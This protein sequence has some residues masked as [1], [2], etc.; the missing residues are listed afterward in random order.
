MRAPTLCGEN[1]E[2]RKASLSVL[3]WAHMDPV[4]HQR[5]PPRVLAWW[6]FVMAIFMGPLGM[7][8]PGLYQEGSSCTTDC[9]CESDG[10][11]LGS[12]SDAFHS[13][14]NKA[15]AKDRC[16][17]ECTGCS[18]AHSLVALPSRASHISLASPPAS[19][20]AVALKAPPSSGTS[21]GVFR[22][23]RA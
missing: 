2:E 4:A 20:F 21:G 8:Q 11:K 6:L 1:V 23:P 15:P 12:D 19:T 16:P 10:A 9:A 14:N 18:G 22:P 7:G 17:S 5:R 13:E 3:P